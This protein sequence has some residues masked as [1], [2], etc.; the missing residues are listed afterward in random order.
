MTPRNSNM[1][2]ERWKRLMEA[3]SFSENLDTY[4]KIITAY[5]EKHRAYHT[6]DHIDACLRHLDAVKDKLAH[7]HEV[8][9]ALWFHDAI[10]KPF[11]GANEEDSADWV[12]A[13]LIENDA[14]AGLIERIYEL[15]IL[16]KAH[17]P[18]DTEDAK[19]MLD[20]DLSILGTHP[21]VYQQFE[22]DIRKEYKQV[23]SFIFRKKRREI[24]QT[25][26]KRPELYNTPYF[27]E[28]LETQARH[29]LSSAIDRL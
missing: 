2:V 15:I 18:P 8:E 17:L 20:I 29:N 1:T 25:F 28:R 4:D 3:F 22:T 5:S 23:P 7:P 27:Y 6:L 16:T 10:Y 19:Y 12:K 9:L 13:F 21:G 26:L 24:L 14:S 11:S